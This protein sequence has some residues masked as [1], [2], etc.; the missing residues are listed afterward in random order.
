MPSWG[1]NH[2]DCTGGKGVGGVGLRRVPGFVLGTEDRIEREGILDGRGG[3]F[4]WIARILQ[5]E[6]PKNIRPIVD[7]ISGTKGD[8]SLRDNFG[9]GVSLCQAESKFSERIPVGWRS[10]SGGLKNIGVVE[11]GKPI[12]LEGK[13]VDFA[14]S[15]EVFLDNRIVARKISDL[16]DRVWGGSKIGA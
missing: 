16:E 11:Q 1:N 13:R 10:S 5:D 3:W 15:N 14:S 9:G 4:T 7:I 2:G 12:N 6:E 8:A